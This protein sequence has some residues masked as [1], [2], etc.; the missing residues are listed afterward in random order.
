MARLRSY[1]PAG[2]SAAPGEHASSFKL[3]SIDK[4][5]Q[6]HTRGRREGRKLAS[7]S[8]SLPSRL[9]V[10]A[11]FLGASAVSASRSVHLPHLV[12]G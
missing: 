4:T 1:W 10:A 2:V 8:S 12:L 3:A 11:A 9:L 7:S 6:Y 5:G